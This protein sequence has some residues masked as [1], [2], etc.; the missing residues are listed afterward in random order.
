MEA[1]PT[2]AAAC[3][4]LPLRPPSSVR[5][6]WYMVHRPRGGRYGHADPRPGPGRWRDCPEHRAV[7][8]QVLRAARG[9]VQAV[10]WPVDDALIMRLLGSLRHSAPEDWR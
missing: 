10:N 7:V 8:Q 4:A 5:N 1:A 6:H 3:R 2:G 9:V